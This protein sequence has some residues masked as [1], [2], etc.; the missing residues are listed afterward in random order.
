MAAR[1]LSVRC[2]ECRE[3]RCSDKAAEQSRARIIRGG[4]TTVSG[5]GLGEGRFALFRDVQE[6]SQQPQDGAEK[7]VNCLA[8]KCAWR[9]VGGPSTMFRRVGS[10]ST[11]TK[12]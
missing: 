3:T 9:K 11:A 4:E 6:V 1:S 12:S 5:G 10:T 7:G 2:T 8:V